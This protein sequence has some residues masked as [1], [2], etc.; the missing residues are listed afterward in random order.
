MRRLLG[1]LRS[2]DTR[3]QLAPQPG[4]GQLREL[5]AEARAAGMSV[6]LTQ[7]GTP[8]PLP[9]GAE[10]AAYRVVQE[11]LTNTR[12]HAGLAAAA[13]V[14][15]RYAEDGLL[16]QVSDDGRGAAAGEGP[17]H[18]LA[19]MRERVEMYG[20][21]MTAGPLPQGGYQVTARIPAPALARPQ[22]GGAA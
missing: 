4:L 9:E 10:L 8:G 16:V 12:K 13:A 22:L 15:L 1:L 18:G 2:G 5:V 7:E 14:T 6:S 3:A 19:G 11:S 20:G 21:T 17:G